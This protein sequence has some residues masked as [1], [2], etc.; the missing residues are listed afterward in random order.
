MPGKA[1]IS[2][3]WPLFWCFS[4]GVENGVFEGVFGPLL[5]FALFGVFGDF[6]DFSYL[7]KFTIMILIL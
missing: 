2:C 3:F 1:K 4:Q 6:C 5:V 7:N